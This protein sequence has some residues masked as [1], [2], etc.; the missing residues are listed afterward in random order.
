MLAC[1]KC[2]VNIEQC[3][4]LDPNN[5]I[6]ITIEMKEGHKLYAK[7]LGEMMVNFSKLMKE[8]ARDCGQKVATL[9]GDVKIE[10][11]KISVTYEIM[12]QKEPKS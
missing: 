1:P 2:G 12:A 8:I 4:A 10:G 5:K 9:V 6:T 11:N 7:T 3:A